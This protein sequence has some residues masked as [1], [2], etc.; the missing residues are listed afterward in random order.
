MQEKSVINIFMRMK[1]KLVA[2]VLIGVL[3]AASIGSKYYNGDHG[4]DPEEIEIIEQFILG[5]DDNPF[6][7]LIAGPASNPFLTKSNWNDATIKFRSLGAYN[8]K[9]AEAKM[10]LFYLENPSIYK[11]YTWENRKKIA[12]ADWK[13]YSREEHLLKTVIAVSF[14]LVV[15]SFAGWVFLFVIC[16]M[17]YFILDRIREFSQAIRGA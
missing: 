5:H 15:G 17:W 8:R 13:V 3:T 12:A 9:L 16:W 4:D 10:M 11:S 2:T 14:F 7:D 6:N 1:P